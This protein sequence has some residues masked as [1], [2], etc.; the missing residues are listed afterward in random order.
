MTEFEAL[1]KAI[2]VLGGQSKA[3]NFL[4]TELNADIKQQHVDG[5]LRRGK[6]LPP[7]Y[8]LVVQYGTYIRGDKV[9]AEELNCDWAVFNN[10]KFQVAANDSIVPEHNQICNYLHG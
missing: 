7:K 3:A 1:K 8:V 2:E 6:R 9:C 5:W 10:P 4:S